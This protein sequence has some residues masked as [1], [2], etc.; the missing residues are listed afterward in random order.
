L[1]S[2]VVYRL[3]VTSLHAGHHAWHPPRSI[4]EIKMVL[5][6]VRSCRKA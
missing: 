1:I 2:V 5:R 4:A 6:M 3:P